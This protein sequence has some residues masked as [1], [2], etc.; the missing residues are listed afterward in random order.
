MMSGGWC[1]AECLPSRWET[2]SVWKLGTNDY[3]THSNF[4]VEKGGETGEM[5]NLL[6]YSAAF[7][8][9]GNA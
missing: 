5:S 6:K 9:D 2:A 4:E 8:V 7:V 1:P 3:G